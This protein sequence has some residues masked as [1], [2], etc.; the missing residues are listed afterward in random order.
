MQRGDIFHV[1]L[2]LAMGRAQSGRGYVLVDS[3]RAFSVA[4]T[5]LMCPITQGGLLAR[6]AG[7]AVSLNG[8]EMM[9]QGAVLCN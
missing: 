8:A 3:E 7:L 5:P 9:A 6:Y 2:D 4:G 1:N